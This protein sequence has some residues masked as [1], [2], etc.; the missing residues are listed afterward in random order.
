[1]VAGVAVLALAGLA[2]WLLRPAPEVRNYPS[3][4]TDIVA[5]GDSLVEGVGA[6]RGNDLVSLLSAR[7]GAPIVNLGESGDT[8]AQGLARLNE[9]DPYHPKVVILLLGGNDYLQ[10]IPEAQTFENL[11]NIIENIEGRGAIVLLLGVRGGVLQDHFANEFERLSD[12]YET[13]YVS[14]VLSGLI[15]HDQLMTDQIHPNDAG[16]AKLAER[17]YPVLKGL[18][19]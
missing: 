15:G 9:L 4:G 2:Y 17:V 5:F 11:G 7:I 1:M 12:T 3:Q 18:L 16:Y 8:T 14:D 19:Q 10:R 13:A 6:T